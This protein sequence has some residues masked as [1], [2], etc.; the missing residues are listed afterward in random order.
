MDVAA[1]EAC[2]SP[3]SKDQTG[4]DL[5]HAKA[6][7][8]APFLLVSSKHSTEYDTG[9]SGIVITPHP[10]AV[11]CSGIQFISK[12]RVITTAGEALQIYAVLYHKLC[13]FKI[14]VLPDCMPTMI[15]ALGIPTHA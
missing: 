4:H 11:S 7:G 10:P 6:T 2:N 8:L 13:Q 12:W 5:D 9:Q 3:T 1:E 15:E 14:T